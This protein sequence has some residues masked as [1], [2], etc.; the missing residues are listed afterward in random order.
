MDTAVDMALGNRLRDEGLRE[1]WRTEA[2]YLV[3]LSPGDAVA[4]YRDGFHTGT[5]LGQTRL[6][7]VDAT[8]SIVVDYRDDDK[9]QGSIVYPVTD[10]VGARLHPD[11]SRII[12][13]DLRGSFAIGEDIEPFN[14]YVREH[15]IPVTRVGSD[16]QLVTR[17]PGFSAL[18][19]EG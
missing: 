7:M 3:G 17:W 19:G 14:N 6:E 16:E 11:G 2:E 8:P 1:L 12:H 13:W 18:S 5:A 15:G 9:D 4:F 10:L